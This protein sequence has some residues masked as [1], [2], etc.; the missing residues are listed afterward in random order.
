MSEDTKMNPIVVSSLI[1]LAS[2][3]AGMITKNCDLNLTPPTA[4]ELT[5]KLGRLEKLEGLPE[6]YDAG[7]VNDVLGY[8]K[9]KL[10]IRD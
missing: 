4:A 3:I 2:K 9:A 5:E 6:E 1:I 8:I 7:M 10:G